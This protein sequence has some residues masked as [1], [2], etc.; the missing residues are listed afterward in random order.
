VD[1]RASRGNAWQ[2]LRGKL[3]HAPEGFHV[4]P[5]II[6]L[7][8]Q[9]SEMGQGKARCRLRFLP[10]ALAFGSILLEGNPVRL[11]GQ[12]SQRGTFNQ[13]HSVLID[14]ETEEEFFCRWQIF[15]PD[16]AFLR[17]S[18]LFALPRAACL[19]I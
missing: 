7:L 14:T 15:S 10:E 1:N 16:Q 3:V 18:Q 12:D 9:R 17:D 11:T 2:K 5:K 4:H 19:G 8:E 13:R 6:K